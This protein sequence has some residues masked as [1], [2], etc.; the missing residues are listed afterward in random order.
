VMSAFQVLLGFQ[1]LMLLIDL[2]FN[3]ASILL[4][5]HNT[6]LLTL[7]ILQDTCLVLS[8]ILL[9]ITFSSTFVFQAGL[10]SLLISRFAPTIA[11]SLIY[12]IL[13]IALHVYSL[14]LRWDSEG[15][16]IWNYWIGALFTVQK[17]VAALYYGTVKRTALNLSDPRLRADSKWLHNKVRSS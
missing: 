11:I 14:R 10:I 15:I 8:L 12:L 13:S 4:Y 7:Y 2:I 9:V 5:Q 17:I 16:H 6:V 3:T 1:M